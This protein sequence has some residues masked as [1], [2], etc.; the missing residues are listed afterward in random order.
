MVK[1]NEKK[2]CFNN[3]LSRFCLFRAM[4]KPTSFAFSFMTWDFMA[5]AK[6]KLNETLITPRLVFLMLIKTTKSFQNEIA[7]EYENSLNS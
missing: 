2:N 7:Y 5:K 3:S 6:F 1:L 4:L